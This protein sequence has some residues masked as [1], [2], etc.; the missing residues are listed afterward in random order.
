VSDFEFTTGYVPG[1]VGRVTE[2]HAK[3]YSQHWGFG[4]F[5]EAKVATEL[6]DYIRNYNSK[7]D[8]I[9]SVAINGTIEASL[10]I[11]RTSERDNVAH[12]RWFIVSESL[13]GK[14]SGNKLM[15]EA[16]NFCRSQKY[17]G[18]YLW[19]FKGLME[20]KHLYEKFG[21]DLEYENEGT[22]W[23]ANVTEQRYR[24]TL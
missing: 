24:L 12:L 16:M 17:K 6:S 13:R 23:G 5:F 2:L 9:F 22:K 11:D 20:A 21:F 10:A 19:T 1:I 18:V 8:C 14:G 3:Y 7:N 15:S 4:A